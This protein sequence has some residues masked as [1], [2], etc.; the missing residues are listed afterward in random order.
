VLN[1]IDLP[2]VGARQAEL[3]AALRAKM[4]H[5]RLLAMSAAGRVGTEEL[6]ERTYRFLQKIK[7]DE[8]AAGAGAGVGAGQQVLPEASLLL[9][10]E[11]AEGEGKVDA[12]ARSSEF[13]IRVEKDGGSVVLSGRAAD[14]LQDEAAS[15]SASAEGSA[16]F[17]A[18]VEALG[19]VESIELTVLAHRQARGAGDLPAAGVRVSLAGG[20]SGPLKFLCARGRLT[21]Q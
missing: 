18:M 9:D 13:S 8:A 19:L 10:A 21:V 20:G 11:E 17:D 7:A 2:A 14:I 4:P 5:A 3:L 1:K 16:R 12:P 6:V 15:A